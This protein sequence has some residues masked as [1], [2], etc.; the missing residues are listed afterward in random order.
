MKTNS[1]IRLVQISAQSKNFNED[2]LISF[3]EDHFEFVKKEGN[4]FGIW[5]YDESAYNTNNETPYYFLSF[6]EKKIIEFWNDE[7][8]YTYYTGTDTVDYSTDILKGE[9]HGVE[10][11]ANVSWRDSQ[12][13]FDNTDYPD[14]IKEKF[15]EEEV[16]EED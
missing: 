6:D 1:I 15:E 5:F 13:Y 11:Y 7:T 16:D 2:E 4:G 3:L 14:W 10:Y 12:I 8:F 9:I